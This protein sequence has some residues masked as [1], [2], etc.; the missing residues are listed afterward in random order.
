MPFEKPIP[1]ER[2]YWVD[3]SRLL[4]GEYPGSEDP[5]T[6]RRKLRSL[7]DAGI[8][9]IV[10]LMEEHETNANGQPFAPYEPLVNAYSREIGATVTCLRFPVPDQGIPS[11][12]RMEQI[13]QAIDESV[14]R[15]HPVYV[16]CWG[17]KGRTGTAVGVY[18]I[19]KGLATRE[20]FEEEI[21]RLRANDPG[22]G[23]SPE[24]ARQ[25]GFVRDFVAGI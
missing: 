14:E 11:Y 13:Q 18:L 16:H 23:R 20:N 15:G 7:L 4:A 9:T 10:N 12:Q 22:G 21:A 6:A 8:R 25:T 1:F 17:G 3:P 19:R 2:S 24:N 5:A